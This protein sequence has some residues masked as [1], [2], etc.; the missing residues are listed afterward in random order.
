MKWLRFL[1]GSALAC[2][3]AA[4][5]QAAPVLSTTGAAVTPP[6]VKPGEAITIAVTVT[7]SGASNADGTATA[8]D[9]WPAGSQATFDVVFT[10]ITTGYQFG[11]T[12]AGALTGT[13]TTAIAGAGGVGTVNLTATSPMQTTEAGAYR[14]Q[15][16]RIAFTGG[17]TWPGAAY[18]SSSTVLTVTGT[19]DLK[20]SSITYPS[21]TNYVGG[22]TIQM[23]LTYRNRRS[24]NGEPN[25]P[26]V[27]SVSGGTFFRIQVVLSNNPVYGDADDFLLTFHDIAVKRDADDVDWPITWTQ[28]LPGNFSGS[29]YVLAKIDSLNAV[30]ETVENDLTEN[31]NNI[32]L[33]VAATRIALQPTTFPT[34]YLASTTGTA[35]GNTSGNGYSDNPSIT[36]DGRYTAFA[37][38]ASNLVAGDTNGARDIFIFDSQNSLVRRL[39]LSQQGAQANAGSNNPSL[40]G[41]GRYVAFS[42]DATNLIVGD[43]NGFADIFIV[44]TLT[45][46]ISLQSVS[47]T[48]AQANGS[49]FRPSV[50]HTGRYLVFESSATNLAAGGTSTGV[51]HIYLRNRD[52]S[53]SGTFDTP[54]NTST[55]LVDVN[56]VNAGNANATQAQISADGSYVTYASRATN[57]AAAATTAG[58]QHIY[59]RD[60]G[61][62]TTTILSVGTAGAEADADSRNPSINRNSGVA[63]GI[64]A[65]GRYIAFGSSATNLIAVDSNGVS[66][67]FVV[68]RTAP[69]TATRV[70]VS[71]SGAQATDPTNTGIF[72]TQIGSINPSISATGRF[73][74]FASLANNLAPGDTVGRY[75][76]AGSG[77]ASLNVYVMDR[78]LSNNGVYDTAGDI[79]TTNVSVN[80]FGY[81]AYAILNVQST[82]ATDIFPVISADGRWVAFPFDTESAPGLIHGATNLISP[83]SNGARDVVLF[84]RRTNSLPNPATPPSVS[85]TSPG[86]GSTALVNTAIP[87]TASATTTTGVVSSVQ[88]FVNGTSIGTTSVFPYTATWTPTAVGTYTLSALVTD[89]FGNIGVS[90]NITVTIN[91]APSVGITSPTPSATVIAGVQRTITAVAS[92]SNP[93][94]V[95]ESVQFFVNGAA[96]STD[97]VAPYSADWTPAAAGTY[98]LTVVATDDFRTQTTSAPVVITV[99]T[100]GGGGGVT[101]PSVSI[102]SPAAGSTVLVNSPQVVTATATA[103]SGTVVSVEFFANGAAIGTAT[104]FPYRVNWR[105]ATPGTFALTATATDQNG[106]QATSAAANI[107]VVAGSAP[108][109]SIITPSSAQTIRP[110][111]PQNITANATGGSGN[112]VS[113][114][115]FANDVLLGTDTTFPYV[116]AWTP[117][118]PGTYVLKAVARD[119]AGNEGTSATITVTATGN[120]PAAPAISIASPLSGSL[121]TV[122][123][124]QTIL[125]NASGATIAS[126]DFYANGV[127]IGNDTTFPYALSWTPTAVG[128]FTLTAI[129]TDSFG[130]QATSNPVA[131]TVV[132]GSTS[133]P[134]VFLTSTPTGT[135]V[136]VNSSVFVSAAALDFDGVIQTVEFYANNQLIGSAAAAPYFT[137]WTPIVA[138]S[139]TITAVATDD[140][141]NRVQSAGSILNA[142]AQVGVLPVVGLNFNDPSLDTPTGTTPAPAPTNAPIPVSY[143]SR[144][145]ISAAAVDQDGSI[146][147]VQF[148]ANGTSIATVTAAPYFTVWQ[149]NTLDDVVLTAL[150][151][152]SSGNAVQTNP[153]LIDTRA[154]VGAANAAVVLV[155]PLDGSSYVTGASIIFSATHNF[156][157]VTPPKIDFYVNGSQFSTVTAAPYQTLLG[158][159]RAGNYVIHAVVRSGTQT[160]VSAPARIIVTSNTAPVI[161][162]TSPTSGMSF[163]VGTPL[164][165]A[166]AASDPDGT[167]DDVQFF[168]NGSALSTDETTPYTAAWNPGAAG[169]YRL[170]AMATDN[171]GNQTLSSTIVVT[172]SGNNP[173]TVAISSPASGLVTG[174][175]GIVALTAQAADADGTVTSVRYLANGIV[176]GSATAAP[177]SATW[178][179]SAP[180]G[181][182]LIAE[183]T[184][185][186]GNVTPSAPV[187][188]TVAANTVPVVAITAPGNGTTVR[189]NTATSITAN[190]SDADGTVT[191]VQFFSN[192]TA[193]GAADTSPPYSTSW[194]PLTE[195]LFRLTAVAID[196]SGSSTTS[197]VVT[198]LVVAAGG[199]D[200]IYTGTYAGLGETGRFSVVNMGGRSAVF[201]GFS[202][203][204]PGSTEAPR[205]YYFPSL[206]V[207][208][209]GNFSRLDAN[210]RSAISGVANDTGTSGTLDNGRLTFIGPISFATAGGVPPGY[211]TGN[212]TDRFGSSLSAIVGSDGTITVYF[213]DG[214]LRDA[215]TGAITRT[216]AFVVT[217]ALNNRLV[218]TVDPATGFVSGSLTGS[219]SADFTAALASGVSFSD[220]F[221]RNLSTR[222]QVGTEAN[223]L[224]AGFVVG[225]TTPKQVLVRAI[226]PSLAPFGIAGALAD[227]QLQ[228]FSG[229]TLAA[230]NG[231]WGG[232]ANLT[233][234]FNRVGAFPLPSSSLDAVLLLT[235]QPGSYTAQVSGVGGGTGVAL[236]ELYDVDNLSPFSPQKVMN[237]AS[238][239]VVGTGQAQLIAGFVVSGNT[240]KRILIRGVGPTLS[241]PPFNVPGVLADPVLTLMRTDGTVVRQNDNWEMGNDP[242]LISNAASAV[243]AFTLAGGSRDAA[244]L[245]SLPPGS[246]TAQVTGTGTSTGVALVEV[247]EIP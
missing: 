169:V 132:A 6:S 68:D 219:T 47:G 187:S 74:T 11:Y 19:P 168:V 120:M 28:L 87:V 12:G 107:T 76:G 186:S 45:G 212:L 67:V 51:T 176:V 162:I 205:I 240:A 65:D 73:V 44:D 106:T 231:N 58:R 246:Y 215:G 46:A 32:W 119:S 39:N 136:A 52:V 7:N 147:S 144:L 50:S 153:I 200:T 42:S 148:F 124:P 97:T 111:T 86:A 150:V 166:S 92:A 93:G 152:D 193:V 55:I 112:I 82:A 29:Y 139:Y 241:A 137:V 172:L 81:Q 1:L 195:G 89:S 128:S 238:R 213:A 225:G 165:I 239:G 191:S 10:N 43:V 104:T 13:V 75:S 233:D 229:S 60:V 56:G 117:D 83:D 135:N 80:R 116:Q 173:P 174:T 138:G 57:L 41:N 211:Y 203:P 26:Y 175:G 177:F 142:T 70:S 121:I 69:G 30:T 190:A 25:V 151:T 242:M 4:V 123:T 84:D 226:G 16:T 197:A 230:S 105:P 222:G 159:V 63:A 110:G 180:G 8:A 3:V 209:V 236:V 115:F 23:T 96:L 149:L 20:V 91:A 185:N 170:T 204:L 179:P 247:Y 171:A 131:A 113:I 21:G 9:T 101:P 90:P 31:G 157:T 98:T 130:Q 208:V 220:G 210:G 154:S 88:F 228:I 145:L 206:P 64:A 71:S 223:I 156:G 161:N 201:I 141:G 35:S 36:A 122:N 59:V 118:G 79:Q 243:R 2:T 134:A 33:D 66:D 17:G 245:I 48:G 184:D 129:A 109:V 237:V 77:N 221:L 54:G 78:D 217:T 207:D 182:T 37:S 244:I 100:A 95:I 234:A 127:L 18:A 188:I 216:G 103:P 218:G 202:Q 167:I 183:A 22:N 158:L 62:S 196:N 114:T 14:I 94:A 126:V 15:A 40:A 108:T 85:I 24:S 192:G 214:T 163:V 49:N 146:A 102:A 198:V 155:S 99:S 140:A 125:A 5:L 178:T 38:E 194:T 53:N 61:S 72:G 164:T 224:I 227:P 189:V 199:G 133:L 143:G 232:G 235:L 181:Y 34:A 160:T 27:P